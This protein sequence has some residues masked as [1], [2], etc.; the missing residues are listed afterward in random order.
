MHE[1]VP[2]IGK[3]R[4][5]FFP[6]PHRDVPVVPHLGDLTGA[7]Q[8]VEGVPAIRTARREPHFGFIQ[9]T[10]SYQQS[11]RAFPCLQSVRKLPG[12]LFQIGEGSIGLALTVVFGGGGKALL[13][14][15]EHGLRIVS[16]VQPEFVLLRWILQ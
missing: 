13:R 1:T 8:E 15:G 5:E 11:D 7:V 12:D 4:A 14:R 10:V 2:D 6:S 3:L 9:P 16:F